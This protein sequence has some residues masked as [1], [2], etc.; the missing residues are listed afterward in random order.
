[1]KKIIIDF[2]VLARP[3][4]S[5]GNLQLEV[6]NGHLGLYHYSAPG[7]GVIV[8]TGTVTSPLAEYLLS[9]VKPVT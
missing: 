2:G 8:A 3:D 4:G 6:S 9:Q 1:M 7:E 5:R